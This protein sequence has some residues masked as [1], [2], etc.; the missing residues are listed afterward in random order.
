[1]P[2]GPPL[3][4]GLA[5]RRQTALIP[6]PRSEA[7]SLPHVASPAMQDDG[8][9]VALIHHSLDDAKAEEIVTIELAGK[10]TIADHMIIAAGRSNTHVGAIA[11]R[12]IRACK[13][14]GHTPR[15]EGLPNCDW[16]LVDVGDVI[17]HLFRPEVRQFYNL[18]KMWSG[19][20]PVE[21]GVSKR[22]TS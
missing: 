22:Q 1:M 13:D 2:S 15:V 6:T 9:L 18:E 8:K 17:V 21:Q 20:R 14:A 16:V 19:D 3:A 4:G 12:V 5:H 7:K 11:D 10:T